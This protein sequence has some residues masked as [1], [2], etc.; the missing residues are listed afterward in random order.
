MLFISPFIT[1]RHHRACFVQ[2]FSAPRHQR[3]LPESCAAPAH[4]RGPRRPSA[5]RSSPAAQ[6]AWA[7]M[8]FGVPGNTVGKN[9]DK[10]WENLENN[11]QP[12]QKK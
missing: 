10:H 3:Y 7:A 12:K 2:V 5:V 8:I 4:R 1:G 6:H 11:G 9:H